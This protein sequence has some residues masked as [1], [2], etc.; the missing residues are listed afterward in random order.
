[1]TRVGFLAAHAHSA[2]GSP[3]LRGNYVMQRLFCMQ[4]PPPP[5]DADTSP[6]DGEGSA[7]TNRE[8]FEERTAPGTCQPCHTVLD[9]FGFGFEHYDAIGGYRDEDNGQPVNAVV[10]LVGTDISGE[11]DGAVEL[12]EQLVQSQQVKDY[13]VS[14]WYRYAL[15]RGIEGA[16]ACALE[17]LTERFEQSGGSFVELI[18]DIAT[19]PEFMRR[20][21]GQE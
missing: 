14:R 7:L 21:E 8:L 1:L 12:S 10:S 17:P 4:L 18:V 15:G 19:S 5:A 6:P 2:N 3:P 13:A 11:V 16:D 20:P 9:S